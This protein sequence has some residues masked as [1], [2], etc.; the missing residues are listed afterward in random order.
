MDL[1]TQRVELCLL[2]HLELVLLRSFERASGRQFRRQYTCCRE[3]RRNN[4][5]LTSDRC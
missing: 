1:C 5:G 4:R 2:P 3:Q